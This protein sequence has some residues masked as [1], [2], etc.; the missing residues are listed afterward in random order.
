MICDSFYLITNSTFLP[1]QKKKEKKKKD[2]RKQ[3]GGDDDDEEDR[4]ITEKLKKLS[5]Q[6]SDEEEEPGTGGCGHCRAAFTV[7]LE[8]ASS[9][10]GFQL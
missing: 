10:S 4:E 9:A 2:R 1:Q 6:P 7:L 8:Q 3:K 5:V